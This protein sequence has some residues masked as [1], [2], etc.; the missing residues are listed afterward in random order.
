MHAIGAYLKYTNWTFNRLV[1]PLTFIYIDLC[2]PNVY[3]IGYKDDRC[4][5]NAYFV[6][7][8]DKSV[9]CI[10][11]IPNHLIKTTIVV[12][13]QNINFPLILYELV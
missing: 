4:D 1:N 13:M 6:A 2:H 12:L 5:N 9:F 7:N 8:N 11:K 10:K 3:Y